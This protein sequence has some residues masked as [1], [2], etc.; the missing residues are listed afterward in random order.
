[1]STRTVRRCPRFHGL[2]KDLIRLSLDLKIRT[3]RGRH[4]DRLVEL[5]NRQVVQGSRNMDDGIRAGSAQLLGGC[6]DGD[7]PEV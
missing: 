5:Q 2:D 3:A 6:G 1:M 7:D 4:R